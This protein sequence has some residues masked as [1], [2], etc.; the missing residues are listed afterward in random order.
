[1]EAADKESILEAI[2]REEELLTTLARKREQALARIKILREK[3]TSLAAIEVREP[4]AQFPEHT[5]S[6]KTSEE[7]VTLFR[8]LFRGREDVFPKLWT[9]KAGKKGYAP[10]CSNEW[11]SSVCGKT[12][13]PPVKCGECSNRKFISVTNQTILDHLQ[14]RHVIGVYPMLENNTC[15]FL[16][17]DFDKESW[18]SDVR[19]FRETCRKANIPVAIERSRSGNGAH[20]WFFFAEPVSAATVRSLGCFLITETMNHRHQL[21]MESYDR[22]FPS[23]DTIPKGG[24]GNLIALPLQLAA[25][26]K[27]NTL[28]LNDEFVPYEDQWAYLASVQRILPDT[29]FQMV[30][31]A[32]RRGKVIGVPLGISE[33]GAEY[34]P[35]NRLPSGGMPEEKIT[36][37][38]PEKV[39][40]IW[41]QRLYI[42]KRELPSPL[43]SRIKRLAAFQNPEFYKKQNMRFSTAQTPRVISCFEEHPEHI[44]IPRGCID[45]LKGLCKDHSITLQL[46]DKCVIGQPISVGFQGD[47]SEAQQK[48]V[49]DLTRYDH[50]VIV[51]PPGFGKTVVGAALIAERKRNALVLVHRKPLLEQWISQ[52]AL[53][54]GI[55]SKEIGQIGAGKNKPNGRLDVAMIQT[56]V[57]KGEVSDLVSNYGHVVVDECHHIP[58]VSFERVLNEVKARYVTGLTATPYR[59]DGH[60]PI[61]HMQCGPVRF[62]VHPKSRESK[63]A[64][65]H[66]LLC[67][68]TD[69]EVG[70][71]T[72]SIQDIFAAL[73]SDDRRNELILNDVKQALKEG[74]MPILLTER[75]EHLDLLA[76]RLCSDVRH[77]V[78]L[79]GRMSVKERRE[80][81]ERLTSIPEGEERLIAATGRYIG[82]GFDDPRLDTLFLAMPFSWK[83]TIVQYAGRLHRTH[84]GKREVRV[85]DYVDAKVPQLLKMHKRRLRGFHA[86]GYRM[87]GQKTT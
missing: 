26:Q 67:R 28:F 66:H 39:Q 14:G 29:V 35:W 16:A 33:E 68:T 42:E 79:S 55:E 70:S 21:G 80:T 84:P 17:V 13:S 3:L 49:H 50:G 82:E 40:V 86:I 41:S 20:A 38:L 19:A 23:Q 73:V 44:S 34:A 10:A 63:A 59:R 48:A 61:V 18:M 5:S 65:T 74:R 37:K 54:L 85:Y 30:N 53:F 81:M 83:G 1:M 78:V 36:G 45:D 7:K 6:P 31:D 71:P 24:F 62:S 76:E 32:S 47:L 2:T 77:L 46:E 58:A 25:R 75:K 60:Q 15:W 27:G 87:D 69:F 64:L 56:L 4:P 52:L 72:A 12:L 9:S 22:L 51:A 8:T 11:E 43:I 57:R